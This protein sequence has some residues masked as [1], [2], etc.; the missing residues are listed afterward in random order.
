[1]VQG[2]QS[3]RQRREKR[4]DDTTPFTFKNPAN[5]TVCGETTFE[6]STSIDL[7]SMS[8]LVAS[9]GHISKL[10]ATIPMSIHSFS[11]NLVTVPKGW[12]ILQASLPTTTIMFNS[13]AFF[14]DNGF[15]SACITGGSVPSFIPNAVST[16]RTH[17][18]SLVEIIAPVVGTTAGVVFA[19]VI[20]ST[21]YFHPRWCIAPFPLVDVGLTC[22]IEVDIDQSLI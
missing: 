2:R 22:F 8:L 17:S 6:W 10:V 18:P 20:I 19:F 12:Y 16:I 21:A 3:W 9:R 14:V 13:S 7:G 5:T 1:M 15:D 11:W 4:H